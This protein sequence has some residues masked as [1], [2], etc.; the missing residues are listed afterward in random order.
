MGLKIHTHDF[1]LS[2]DLDLKLLVGRVFEG[3]RPYTYNERA[4]AIDNW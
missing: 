4:K 1:V 2:S 3:E